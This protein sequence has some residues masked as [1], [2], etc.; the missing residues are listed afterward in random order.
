MRALHSGPWSAGSEAGVARCRRAVVRRERGY[1]MEWPCRVGRARV[2]WRSESGKTA[3]N[4]PRRIRAAVLRR[5]TR[6]CQGARALRRSKER[7]V[8]FHR[9]RGPAQRWQV[10][11]VHGAHEQRRPRC[12]LSF[13]HHRAQRRHRPGAGPAS[14]RAGENRPS[15]EDRAG[16]G[17]VRGHRRF[18]G[19]RQPGRRS[20]QPVLGQHP[21]DRRHL[22]GR[23]L[24]LRPRRHARGGQGE[25]AERRR[26]HQDRAHPGRHRHH[27]EGAAALGEGR[28][29]RQGRR[30]EA[31]DREEDARGP[32]RRP[33]RPHA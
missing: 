6:R 2:R 9:Y 11:A 8:T 32:Q 29:A 10:H 17:G 16:D 24:L 23:A 31:R 4:G 25:P 28:E 12:Q 14:G 13:R 20:G 33:S 7:H 3:Y 5:C 26:H 1:R 22:R 19:G 21:R 27:R 18:G 30:A 15:G